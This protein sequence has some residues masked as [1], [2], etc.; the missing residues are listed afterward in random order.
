M[1]EK[2]AKMATRA[3]VEAELAKRSTLWN[4]A[5]KTKYDLYTRDAHSLLVYGPVYNGKPPLRW[6]SEKMMLSGDAA[7]PYG[8][9]GQ[10][11][12][13]AL[14]DAKALGD[15]IARG[16]TEDDKREF[17]RSRSQEAR[18]LGEAAEKR[19][20]KEPSSSRLAILGEGV[21]MKTVEIFTTGR[22]RF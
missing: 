7:H 16:F 5:L 12:S 6:Y 20:A 9:G 1:S 3:S 18:K 19:N 15:V 4:P 17:Q 8:P 2:D 22:L 14:K 11:I 21:F 13:M 10:G